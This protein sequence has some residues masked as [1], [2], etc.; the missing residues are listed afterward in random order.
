MSFSMAAL[1]SVAQQELT[2]ASQAGDIFA[3]FHDKIH[4]GSH[5][6]NQDEHAS[7]ARIPVIQSIENLS[8][9]GDYDDDD[10]SDKEYSMS[11]DEE[12]HDVQSK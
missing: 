8:G 5:F 11:N 6:D 3:P 10:E 12:Q 9:D 4:L 1:L 2:P 7:S